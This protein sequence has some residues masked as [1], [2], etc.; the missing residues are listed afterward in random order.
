MVDAGDLKSLAPK[1]CGFESRPRHCD[2][3]ELPLHIL[4]VIGIVAVAYRWM[5]SVLRVLGSGAEAFLAGEVARTRADRGDLTGMAEASVHAERARRARAGAIFALMLWTALLV[6][7]AWALP[8]PDAVYASYATLWVV[9]G[10]RRGV[11]AVPRN[12]S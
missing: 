10:V 7:P 3:M 11:G 9:A 8:W 5:R 2:F 1:A 6:L 4:A 12:R